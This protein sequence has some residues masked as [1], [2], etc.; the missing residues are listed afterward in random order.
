MT[1]IRV[2]TDH[3]EL[4]NTGQVDHAQLD[5]LV[6]NTAFVIVSGASGPVPPSARR[7]VAGT[8]ISINDGGPG[9]DLTITATGAASAQISWNEVPIGSNDGA[10]KV[11]TL[12]FSPSPSSTLMLFIN[13]VKQR[14]GVD[15]DYTLTGSLINLITDYRS[16]SN[17]DATYPY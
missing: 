17:I 5:D 14:Q 10:N 4:D 9:G 8:G 15:S 16:G 2:I 3:D 7:L 1:A 11:F 6:N 13:G 12:A